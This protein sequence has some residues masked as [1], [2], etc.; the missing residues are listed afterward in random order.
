[1]TFG[2]AT[3]DL[4]LQPQDASPYTATSYAEAQEDTKRS[5][6]AVHLKNPPPGETAA[7]ALDRM[8]SRTDVD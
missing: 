7:G 4:L 6:V 2:D 1:V 8:R 3:V 5:L